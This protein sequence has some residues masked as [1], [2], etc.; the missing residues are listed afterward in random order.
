MSPENKLVKSNSL[1]CTARKDNRLKSSIFFSQDS[2]SPK[3]GKEK[4]REKEREREGGVEEVRSGDGRRGKGRW[5]GT[6]RELSSRL[7][8]L[9]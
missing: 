2:S 8:P 9:L 6:K 1:L 3:E 7:R 4:E 5:G